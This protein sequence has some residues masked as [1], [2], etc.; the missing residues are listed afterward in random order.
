MSGELSFRLRLIN[1]ILS[2]YEPFD[3][4]SYKDESVRIS[5]KDYSGL[6]ECKIKIINI[7][8][9]SK[10]YNF[11]M[12]IP[13]INIYELIDILMSLE[14]LV[15]GFIP[16]YSSGMGILDNLIKNLYEKIHNIKRIHTLENSNS[17]IEI[18][19]NEIINRLI[20]IVNEIT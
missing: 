2:S 4:I 1:K 6:D 13:E 16:N 14:Y 11:N 3:F 12:H 17:S 15:G 20:N 19:S 18:K 7:N 8:F 9:I 10:G 5:I